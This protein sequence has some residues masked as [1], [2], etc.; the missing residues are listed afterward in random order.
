M[1]RAIAFYEM[2]GFKL[3]VRDSW[4]VGSK[5]LD[6]IVGMADSAAEFA[7]LWA[8]NTHLELFQYKSPVGKSRD[9]SMRAC[10]HGY[11]HLC[12]DVTDIDMEYERLKAGGMT[13]STVPQTAFGVRAIYGQDP[14]GNLIE[15][16]EILDWDVVKLPATIKIGGL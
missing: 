8:G 10:D 5:E 7:M 2:I 14:D 12:I 4:E 9:E 1:D 3:R 16:Q 11:T 15:L 6:A 13:F